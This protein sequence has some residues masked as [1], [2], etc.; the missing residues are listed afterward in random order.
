MLRR[1]L[2][3]L[4]VLPIS[5]GLVM[6]AVA[7]RHAVTLFVDPLSGADG[8]SIDLPLFLVVSAAMIIGVLLGGTAAWLSQGRYRK[9]ARRSA[10]E[11][12]SA[13]DEVEELRASTREA[14]ARTA[15]AHRRNAA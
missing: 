5:V 8:A 9:A 3:I 12:R 2:L 13:H 1:V 15:L 10:R 6:L 11:A 4:I 14:P 7:N